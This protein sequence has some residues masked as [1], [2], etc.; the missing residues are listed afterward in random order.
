MKSHMCSDDI[1]VDNRSS[2]TFIQVQI[3]ASKTDPFRHGVTIYIGATDGPLCPVTL[4]LSCMVTRG[5]EAG[6]LFK[7]AD[8]RYL[9][10]ENFVSHVLLVLNAAGLAAKTMQGTTSV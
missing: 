2:P 9:T 4:V 6:P 5:D 10:W 7:W 8:G 3:N 1:Q